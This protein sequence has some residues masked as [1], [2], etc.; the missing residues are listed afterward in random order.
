MKRAAEADDPRRRLLIKALAAGLFSGRV[1]GVSGSVAAQVSGGR[2]A[3]LPADRSVFERTG[4]ATVN[5]KPVA[6]TR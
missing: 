3:K 2:P 1:S 4:T 5:D 6:G